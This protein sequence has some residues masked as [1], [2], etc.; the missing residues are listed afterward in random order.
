MIETNKDKLLKVAVMGEIVP[1]GSGGYRPTWNG[2]PKMSLGMGGIKY[3]L[4]V[5]DPCYGWASGDH[6]EPGVTIRGKENPSPSQCA[7]A[8]LACIGNEARLTS[9]EAKNEMGV[10]T[11]RHAGS[12]DLVWFPPET[13]EKLAI[14]DKV[15]IKAHGV[16]LKIKGFEDVR[17]NKCSPRLLENMGIE[18]DGDQLVVPVAA[19]IPGFLMGS[20]IGSSQNVEPGDYDIQTTDPAS[21]EKYGLKKLRLGDIVLLQDQ[22]CMNGRGYYK[23]AMTIGTIIHGWSDSAGHGPGVNPLL[24][25]VGGRIRTVIDPRANTARYLGLRDDL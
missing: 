25:T 10:F 2:V 13:I 4:R 22:L 14:G 24:S 17:V 12:D 9:G 15:Q 7:L 23:G 6:V 18:I 20:G 11:G 16:G 8:L 21:N 19:E 3:N 1:C 5:G